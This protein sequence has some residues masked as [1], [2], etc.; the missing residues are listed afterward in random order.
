MWPCSPIAFIHT[1]TAPYINN[2]LKPA[3]DASKQAGKPWQI[4]AA[5]SLMGPYVLPP[6]DKFF[7]DVPSLIQ[8]VVKA[9]IDGLL[10]Q[11][12]SLALRAEIALAAVN[13]EWNADD[14]W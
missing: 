12:Q 10:S 14:Y 4:W 1:Q 11:N 7:L 6:A 8:P 13:M 2:V 5:N 3:F 9:A